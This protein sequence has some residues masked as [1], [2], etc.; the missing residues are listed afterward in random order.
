MEKLDL[1]IHSSFSDGDYNIKELIK[2]IKDKKIDIFSITDHDSTESIK[3]LKEIPDISYIPGI[4][5]SAKLNKTKMHILGYG[6][7]EDGVISQKCKEIKEIKQ[8]LI[9]EIIKD[10]IKK[11]YKI[12]YPID[13]KPL[14]KVDVAKLLVEK[15]Y[16]KTV[17][18]AFYNILGQYKIGNQIRIDARKVIELIN[19]EEAI[20]ILAHPF[21]IPKKQNIII[22]YIIDELIE[23]GIK[24]L[25]VYTTKHTKEESEYLLKICEKKNLLISSGSDYHGI[26]KPNVDLGDNIK[27][28][29]T[30]EAIKKKTIKHKWCN[31]QCLQ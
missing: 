2:K 3:V 15:Q 31:I 21:E 9:Y 11:N 1:H 20:P 23:C 7:K 4:E 8:E 10:L 24:G 27:G 16:A 22:D 25:E 26:S 17:K 29:E 28:E 18:E 6:I 12:E 5:M 19:E 13:N 14:S 30:S